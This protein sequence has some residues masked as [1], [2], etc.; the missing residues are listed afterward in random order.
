MRVLTAEETQLALNVTTDAGGLGT[1]VVVSA[2]KIN[3]T[4]E[5]L[6]CLAGRNW[7]NDEVVNF[8]RELMKERES[9]RMRTTGTPVEVLYMT[10]FFLAKLVSDEAGYQYSEVQRWTRAF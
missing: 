2:F 7:L 6:S 5:M 8:Y 3:M 10:S 1:E 9:N 4:R